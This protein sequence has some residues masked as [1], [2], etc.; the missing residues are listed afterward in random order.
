M[1]SYLDE[2]KNTLLTP[3]EGDGPKLWGWH[4]LAS[5]AITVALLVFL[6]SYVDLAQVW[7]ELIAS[8]KQLLVFAA[9]S[10][11]GTYPVR[12]I[13]WRNQP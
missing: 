9:L 7:R 10:H 12:G 5:I 8:D 4:S 3:S 6:A 2:G 13:C 11:Y 1:N